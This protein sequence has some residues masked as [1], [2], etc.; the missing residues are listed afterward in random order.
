M[1]PI[2]GRGRA[3]TLAEIAIVVEP[4]RTK[5]GA[6]GFDGL[7]GGL[8]KC[9]RARVEDRAGAT[10]HPASPLTSKHPLHR[11]DDDRKRGTSQTG[12]SV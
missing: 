8:H 7:D 3:R 12:I 10:A 9:T 2:V 4:L 5:P 6:L 1:G 11:R